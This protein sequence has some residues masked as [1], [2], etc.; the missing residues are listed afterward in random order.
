M[1]WEGKIGEAPDGF[2]IGKSGKVNVAMALPGALMVLSPDGKEITRTPATPE[3]NAQLEI[4]YDT[5]ASVAF[6]GCDVLITNQA[7]FGNPAHP[8]VLKVNVGEEGKP[9]FRPNSP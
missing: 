1:F 8:A 7:F 5:P 9:L 6:N 2:A 4:P 3:E